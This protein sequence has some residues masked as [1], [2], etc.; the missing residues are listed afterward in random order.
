MGGEFLKTVLAFCLISL[1]SLSYSQ[2]GS[3]EQA[4]ELIAKGYESYEKNNLDS[5]L[6]YFNLASI[7]Y[8]D[9]KQWDSYISSL[10]D[11]A[12]IN[13]YLNDFGEFKK[14]AFKAYED[15]K[16]YLD[17]NN[18][19]RITALNN[20]NIYYY[21]L[22]DFEKS[23]DIIQETILLDI[24]NKA[25]KLEIAK[26]YLNLGNSYKFL[27]DM[28]NASS[29]YRKALEIQNGSIPDDPIISNTYQSIGRV[30][31]QSNQLDSAIHH[32]LEAEKLVESI[33]KNSPLIN[34]KIENY[35]VL[36]ELKNRKQ[37]YQKSRHYIDLTL[38]LP[39]SD[40]YKILLQETL[41]KNFLY[42]GNYND[43][44]K[45]LLKGEQIANQNN[46]RNT[47]PLKSRRLI[48]LATAYTHLSD[49]KKALSVYQ[50]ALG[51]LALDFE[52]ENYNVNPNFEGLRS[53]P[54]A[55]AILNNKAEVL[56]QLYQTSKNQDYLDASYNTYMTATDLISDIRQ[57]IVTIESKKALSEKTTSSYE[58]A[59]KTAL[60]LF[61]L[62]GDFQYKSKAFSIAESNKALLLLENINDQMAKGFA[63]I[64]DSLL[65]KEKDLKLRLAFEKKSLLGDNK[66]DAS[67]KDKIFNLQQ[68]LDG[69]IRNF[70]KN[71]PRYFEMKYKND[72]VDLKLV[73]EDLK[74]NSSAL[75][76]Y[77]VGAECIY[78]FVVSAD[79]LSIVTI[80]DKELVFD[81]IKKLNEVISNS[82]NDANA[83]SD[84]N[85][86][87]TAAYNLYSNVLAPGLKQLS[88]EVNNLSII[89]DDQLNYIPFSTLLIAPTDIGN[90]SYD[91]SNLE[92][93]L[94]KHSVSYHYS[95][96][97]LHKTKQRIKVLHENNFIGFAPSFKE[98]SLATNR[99]CTS[100][101]LY[102]LQCSEEEI[103]QID[104]LISGQTYNNNNATK[105]TF[106]QQ[107][108]SATIVH[109]A[110]HAC[111]D[112]SDSNL[113][114]IFFTDDYL[115]NYDLYNL[116][117]NAELAVLSACNT[118]S[119][120]LIKGEG[121]MSLARSFINAGC[122]STLMS[123][124]SVDDC[125]T[126][127]IMVHFYEGIKG[128]EKK[129][130]ALQNAKLNYLQSSS[131]TKM[132]PYY[133]AA[134][135]PFGDMAPIQLQSQW[136]SLL[137][138]LPIV[139]LFIIGFFF[140]RKK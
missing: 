65:A 86:Y 139:L 123:L 39:L 54:D 55:L 11:I 50:S 136:N 91:L 33:D 140:F 69:L 92:Y 12:F 105:N 76:E 7:E 34:T 37:D 95:A 51:V 94:E 89:P 131:R 26:S 84:F 111:I 32:F 125:A 130:E 108:Q 75:L 46:K 30:F 45:V 1:A 74:K 104:Q 70:E 85:Q 82:P 48:N 53:K 122:A 20:M 100:D 96:T 16:K 117:L 112:E 71:Y 5:A 29:Y 14:F 49:Y 133:W 99:S 102:S 77:F 129:E 73:Q 42:R 79:D 110:T 44:I 116:E 21:S 62:T 19:F 72:P 127:D 28:E 66:G 90:P 2:S 98:A 36:S 121:V 52:D 67:I 9:V 56:Y 119:G 128:G 41:A 80:E 114:K 87:T 27:G 58:G 15:S 17:T 35:L 23:I 57:G 63:G 134:F 3:E 124:W 126:S 120:E 106:E 132:H 31:Q 137:Y 8:H 10:N 40:Y 47:P 43:A 115:S 60:R 59:I 81:N 78:L 107:A 113:N 68:E 13:Y 103:N 25:S 109:L 135:V 64:P 24:E 4:D 93:V 101:E 83:K 18:E 6:F 138:L 22:G 38:A 88:S 97:L 118:G 61:A